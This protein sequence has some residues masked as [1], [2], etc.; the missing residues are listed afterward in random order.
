[1]EDLEL[2]LKQ[3]IVDVLLLKDVHAAE[4][5]SQAPLLVAGL[6][7]DSIDALE[8]A[9]AISKRY[10]VK[11][12]TQEAENRAAFGSVRA[13]ADFIQRYRVAVPS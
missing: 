6:G 5:D 2:E 13:L 3:L 1:M 7:L 9:M 12:R 4:I 11:F 10:G 8:L